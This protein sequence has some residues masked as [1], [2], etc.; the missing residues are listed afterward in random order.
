MNFILDFENMPDYVLLRTNGSIEVEG[1][2]KMMNDLLNSLEWITDSPQI[3][4]HRELD[5][6]GM[7]ADEMKDIWGIIKNHSERLGDGPCAFV[8]GDELGFG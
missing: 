4:D 6:T 8:V 1:V 2:D 7:A 5:L 3:V